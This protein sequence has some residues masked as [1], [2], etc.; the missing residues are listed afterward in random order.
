MFEMKDNR[1][2]AR[3]FW[4]CRKENVKFIAVHRSDGVLAIYSLLEL[5]RKPGVD[6]VDLC[7]ANLMRY[8]VAAR[9]QLRAATLT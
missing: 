6:V 7:S 5:L 2:W 3:S 9:F 1:E 4:C 8:R